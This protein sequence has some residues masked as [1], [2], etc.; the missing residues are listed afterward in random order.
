MD[1]RSVIFKV[2]KAFEREPHTSIT[3][4]RAALARL[5]LMVPVEVVL[6]RVLAAEDV[7]SFT[8]GQ[9]GIAKAIQKLERPTLE[10]KLTPKR[11][12]G[13]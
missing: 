5:K 8:Q 10:W 12:V 1:H 13:I 7:F 4:E 2:Y 6:Q 9:P 3:G 11:S